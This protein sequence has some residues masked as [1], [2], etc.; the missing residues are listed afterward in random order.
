[1]YAAQVGYSESENEPASDAPAAAAAAAAAAAGKKRGSSS[2]GKRQRHPADAS[3]K[4]TYEVGA[5]GA[6]REVHGHM[7]GPDE[8]DLIES[9]DSDKVRFLCWR[10]CVMVRDAGFWVCR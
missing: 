4:H 10:F 1:M 9:D 6:V 5:A 2:S 8:A 3:G 7:L